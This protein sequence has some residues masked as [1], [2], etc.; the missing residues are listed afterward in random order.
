LHVPFVPLE[1]QAVTNVA[2]RA[3][4]AGVRKT[5]GAGA[6]S[7]MRSGKAPVGG[8]KPAFDQKRRR[9]ERD[10]TRITACFGTCERRREKLLGTGVARVE[11]AASPRRK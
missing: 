1:Y 7:A 5:D 11:L 2:P 4:I 10:I 8:A 9:G 3:L 6:A